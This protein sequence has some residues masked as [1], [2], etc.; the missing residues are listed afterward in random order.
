MASR[1]KI[2]ITEQFETVS[3]TVTIPDLNVLVCGPCYHIEDYTATNKSN[4]LIASTYGTKND[5]T[6]TSGAPTNRPL[7][8]TTAI[9]I[10]SP[11]NNATGAILDKDSVIVYLDEV[12]V[13]ITGANDGAAT[14]NSVTFTSAGA[15]F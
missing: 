12:L 2:K 14:N 9:T 11:V 15:T 10:S 13:H 3:T 8:N 1:P 7:V 4:I 6:G 5:T